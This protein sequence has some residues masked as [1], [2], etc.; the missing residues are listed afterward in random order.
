MARKYCDLHKPGQWWEKQKRLWYARQVLQSIT[1]DRYI[2][3]NEVPVSALIKRVQRLQYE[4]VDDAVF[5]GDPR[6][7]AYLRLILDRR[8][9]LAIEANEPDDVIARLCAARRCLTDRLYKRLDDGLKT[10]T[11]GDYRSGEW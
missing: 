3:V 6:K 7:V 11:V 8:I 4:F 10:G 5:A 2:L 9:A 1:K